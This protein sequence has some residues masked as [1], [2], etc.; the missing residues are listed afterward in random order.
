MC[1]FYFYVFQSGEL[2]CKVLCGFG[3]AREGRVIIMS[4]NWVQAQRKEGSEF[5]F[6]RCENLLF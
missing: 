5:R 1:T 2:E 3:F 4:G 6:Y